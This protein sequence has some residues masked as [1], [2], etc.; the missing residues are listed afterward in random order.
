MVWKFMLCVCSPTNFSNI[1]LNFC[2]PTYYSFTNIQKI[3]HQHF[4]SSIR[5]FIT[6]IKRT[7]RHTKFYLDC[8]F[9]MLLVDTMAAT[10]SLHTFFINITTAISIIWIVTLLQYHCA[11]VKHKTDTTSNRDWI[12]TK[13]ENLNLILHLLL[14]LNNVSLTRRQDGSIWKI[15]YLNI[16]YII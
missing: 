8:M 2:F 14:Y 16:D 13:T 1:H 12:W 11:P 7:D 3:L 10:K 5:A 9:K 6:E 4:F 15:R